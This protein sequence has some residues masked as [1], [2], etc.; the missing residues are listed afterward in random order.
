MEGKNR[1]R[2]TAKLADGGL[3]PLV[4][5]HVELASLGGE[6][7]CYR[8]KPLLPLPIVVGGEEGG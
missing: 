5:R 4:P 7:V 2:S 1:P 3:E 6:V 8:L